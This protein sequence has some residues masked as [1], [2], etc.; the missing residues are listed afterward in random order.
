M[1]R[2]RWQRIDS[3][4]HEA[5]ERPASERG[6]FLDAACGDDP[7]LRR[8]VE[9][10]LARDDAEAQED[11]VG[12]VLSGAASTLVEPDDGS[13]W[14][15]RRVGPW[16]VEREIGRG[17][18]GRVLLAHRADG[19]FDRKVAV[20]VALAGL[21]GAR[22]AERLE[23]ERRI[24]AGLDHPTIA[25]LIDGGTT[26][27]GVP[28]V[29]MEHVE[30]EPIDVDCARRGL[31]V[32]ERLELFLEV[33]AAVSHAHRALVVHRD[34]KP[35]NILVTPE[36]NPKLLD[37][38]IATLLAPDDVDGAQA[39]ATLM[40]AL[41]P[42]YASPEQVRG[43]PITTATDV[44][45][46]GVVLYEL[47]T[48]TRPFALA[49]HTPAQLEKVITTEDPPRP[50]TRVERRRQATDETSQPTGIRGRRL[51]GDLD[52]IVL[53]ALRKEPSRRY[54]DVEALAEDIRRHLDGRPVEARPATWTYRFRRFVGRHRA[55]TVFGSVA[56]VALAAG[57]VYHV[58]RLSTE[59]DRALY[60][61]D[62]AS[63][64]SAF[65]ENLFNA[66]MPESGDA[67]DLTAVDLLDRGAA[68]VDAE[69]AD[70]PLLRAELQRMI[71]NAY[72][73]LAAL[74]P[75]EALLETA[76]ATAVAEAGDDSVEAARVR[77]NLG[78][79]YYAQDREEEAVE[80]TMRALAV[81]RDHDEHDAQEATSILNLAHLRLRAGAYDEAME[82]ARAAYDQ[83]LALFGE[84]DARTLGPRFLIARIHARLMEHDEAR[85]Q[86]ED[87]LA[88]QIAL[89]GE[90][91]RDVASTLDDLS[92]VMES[93][94][95]NHAA[96]E[97]GERALAIEREILGDEHPTVAISK[98]NLSGKHSEAGNHERAEE[99]C[100]GAL[101][102][103]MRHLPPTH[104]NIAAGHE[105]LANILVNGGRYD[106]AVAEAALA[107]ETARARYTTDHPSLARLEINIARVLRLSGGLQGAAELARVSLERWRRV[108]PEDDVE[109]VITRAILGE[110]LLERGLPAEALAEM[111]PAC[112]VLGM[113]LEPDDPGLAGRRFHM[114]RT[115]SVL[116][117]H[118][119]A[120][121][122]HDEVLAVRE[123]T[124][125]PGPLVAD[126]LHA[127]GENALRT[128][129][130]PAARERLEAALAM[131]RG[132]YDRGHFEVAISLA[133]IADLEVADGDVQAAVRAAREAI[134]VAEDVGAIELH[135]ATGRA[136]LARALAA[137]G[138][139]AARL[140]AIAAVEQALPVMRAAYAPGSAKVRNA[141]ALLSDLEATERG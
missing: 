51:R 95:D 48:G 69:L 40:R 72:R 120:A 125:G 5:A 47:L 6:A 11:A 29:V 4:F 111:E 87:I 16:Q 42:D 18:M 62:R 7:D 88:R 138:S 121:A 25:R 28:Y 98:F 75:A 37:F 66:S 52:N 132:A 56:L 128:G 73:R 106:D 119:R 136:A 13:E 36:G 12:G 112:E 61:A 127:I 1:D 118:E 115:L 19:A 21:S 2:E 99:L 10:L 50:S 9:E 94:G 90:N 113:K 34:L 114:A 68:R 60:Q 103:W 35:G 43:D 91:H 57:V 130:L 54:P 24:L 135:R 74:E 117:D 85:S 67:K 116:G 38:G 70:D 49:G 110:T 26:E 80:V 58:H 78:G 122:L 17:G 20:K 140:E 33:C 139:P 30:G 84:D 23:S 45:A 109:L 79:L 104:G 64:T 93:L 31:G 44:Y 107:L 102:S 41:T 53:K 77:L 46:L 55:A 86:F 101:E 14:D 126:S 92:S 105:R 100:R 63:K 59:R 124:F 97:L 3:L 65:L 22:Y 137:D 8:E 15:G 133:A 76:L 27:D 131:R 89:L 123:S 108:V 96:I 129:D 39:T 32:R 134:A 83:R 81:L 71:G 141:E 82:L